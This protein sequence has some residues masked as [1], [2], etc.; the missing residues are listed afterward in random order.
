[1]P[2]INEDECIEAGVDPAAVRRIAKRLES[3]A[4]EAS[5]MGLTVF[6]GSGSG[7][8]RAAGGDL[9]D[10]PLILASMAGS[11]D[12]GDGGCSQGE[13]GFIRGEGI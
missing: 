3:A 5:K 1:M 2:S 6:G 12:G 4:R 13:D 11:W 9:H 7:D 10:R 8:I